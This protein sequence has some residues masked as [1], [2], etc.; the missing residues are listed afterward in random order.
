M[1]Y[2]ALTLFKKTHQAHYVIAAI[3]SPKSIT[4]S[5]LIW[6]FPPWAYSW[7]KF[8]WLRPWGTFCFAQQDM[9]LVRK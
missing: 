9:M 1:K 7:K 6:W 2:G 3:H 5:W 8:S 4:W